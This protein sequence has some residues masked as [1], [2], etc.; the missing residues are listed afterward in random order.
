MDLAH[1]KKEKSNGLNNGIFYLIWLPP[2]KE[3][4]NLSPFF[5]RL[6]Q[7]IAEPFMGGTEIPSSVKTV[8]PPNSTSFSFVIFIKDQMLFILVE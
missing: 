6:Y 5:F 4:W 2:C 3:K 1:V 8:S 7:N